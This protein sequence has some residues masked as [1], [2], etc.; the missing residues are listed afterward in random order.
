MSE[1]Y[2][3]TDGELMNRHHP[4]T[5]EIPK[6]KDRLDAKIGSHV[7]LGFMFADGENRERMWVKVVGAIKTQTETK[8]TGTLANDPVTTGL[9]KHGD[10]IE[11][12]H[13][14]IISLE[15]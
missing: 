1:K 11:F 6:L 13:T 5:F 8:Y 2:E 7:K 12:D 14:N 3:L 15:N 4:R 9:V 10:T